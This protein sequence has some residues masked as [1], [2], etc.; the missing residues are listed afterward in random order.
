MAQAT[1]VKGHDLVI[2]AKIMEAMGRRKIPLSF[3][4]W[5]YIPQL[6]SIPVGAIMTIVPSA[7]TSRLKFG[8][9]AHNAMIFPSWA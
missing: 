9:A 3:A 1:L 4:D 7:L 8:L 2:G 5:T 6:V